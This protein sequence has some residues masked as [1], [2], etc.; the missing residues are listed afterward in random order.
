[1]VFVFEIVVVFFFLTFIHGIGDS[2]GKFHVFMCEFDRAMGLA[3]PHKKSMIVEGLS[4]SSSTGALDK[5]CTYRW[6]YLFAGFLKDN[7]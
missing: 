5:C 3:L 2:S 1:M 6:Q 7:R 4:N